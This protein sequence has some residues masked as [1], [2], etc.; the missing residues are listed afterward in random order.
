[1][2]LEQYILLG[3]V[4]GTEEQAALL[5]QTRGGSRIGYFFRRLFL[6]LSIL[7]E[8]YPV[9]NKYPV[10]YLFCQI[11]RWFTLLFDKEKRKNAINRARYS[12]DTETYLHMIKALKVR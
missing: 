4:F 8:D 2:Q 10:F 6:P 9:L 12:G 11:H 3:G 5:E 1:M 7:R